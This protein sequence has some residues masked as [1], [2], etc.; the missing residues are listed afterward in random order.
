LG[1]SLSIGEFSQMIGEAG[2][3]TMQMSQVHRGLM[4]VTGGLASAFNTRW[5]ASPPHWC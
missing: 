2:G 3:A 1:I 5:S 4:T